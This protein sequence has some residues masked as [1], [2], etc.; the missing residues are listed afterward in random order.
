M[1]IFE[2]PTSEF[3][4]IHLNSVDPE[5]GINIRMIERVWSSA[6]WRNKKHR[7]TAHNLLES[8]LSE[9]TFRQGMQE[10][11]PFDAFLNVFAIV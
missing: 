6:K 7:G 9:F 4:S 10:D 5:T 3:E 1:N 8:Y 11:D 2:L